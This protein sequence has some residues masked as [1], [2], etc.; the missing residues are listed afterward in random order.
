MPTPMP[1]PTWSL[2]VSFFDT[3]SSWSQV[4]GTSA[5]VS[6]AFAHESVLICRRE[7]REVL[8]HAV[9]LALVGEGLAQRLV[10][11]VVVADLVGVGVEAA[12]LGVV[13]E[14]RGV[15]VEHV[16]GVAAGEALRELL[17]HVAGDG[18]GDGVAGL[19]R[20]GVGGVP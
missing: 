6:P 18:D 8:G 7:R 9:E 20:P 15:H 10:E 14:P 13:G 17:R 5:S 12:V 19:L 16:G 4:V 2:V 3:A 1:S 11:V